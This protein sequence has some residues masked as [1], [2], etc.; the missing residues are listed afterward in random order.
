T[1]LLF[2]VTILALFSVYPQGSMSKSRKHFFK[3]GD[4]SNP[5]AIKNKKA[6]EKFRDKVNN[7]KSFKDWH[8]VQ[9]K[10][11]DLQNAEWT[12]IGISGS[13]KYFE[14]TYDGNGH[15]IKNLNVSSAHAG[16]FG[17]LNGTVK[18]LGIESGTIAGDYAG[19]IASRS[20]GENAALINCYNKAAVT[21]KFRA[22]GIADD[23]GKGTIINC[24]NEGTVTA[25]VTGE[26]VSY[27]AADII[28]AH[29][30]SSG[31]PNTFDGNYTEFNSAEKKITD[32]LNDGLFHLIS[33]KV[34]DRSAVKKWR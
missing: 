3:C 16:F 29:S 34:I 19:S 22:G 9:T 21:G 2:S 33:Q 6:L 32:K 18:N 5:C 4:K 31:L 13:D 14:G 23:F 11:I 7:G 17:V 8:F 15:V 30:E 25:P 27:N 12:P 24:A 20:G 10:D 1:A 26:I 28:A